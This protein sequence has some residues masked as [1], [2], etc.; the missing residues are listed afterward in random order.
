MMNR[1]VDQG[2][3]DLDVFMFYCEH[4]DNPC[5]MVV[6]GQRHDIRSFYERM[7]TEALKRFSNPF[8]K[9]LLEKKI[10]ERS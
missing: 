5:S 6:D 3:T 1:S 2:P 4:L 9:S 7:A 10:K 8:L